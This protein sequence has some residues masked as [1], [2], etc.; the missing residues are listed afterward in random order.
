[1][2]SISYH[3]NQTVF[4]VLRSFDAD[5]S[6]IRSKVLTALPFVV[7]L[8]ADKATILPVESEDCL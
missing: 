3:P 1:M 5:V 6:I 8:Y 4:E 7:G 2:L